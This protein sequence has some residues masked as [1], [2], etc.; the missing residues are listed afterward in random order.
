MPDCRA[1]ELVTPSDTN[2]R[3]P[4]GVGHLGSYFATRE[5]SPAGEAVS[6]MI[7]GGSLGGIEATGSYAGDPYLV[8]RSASG[9]STS[10]AGPSALEAPAISPGSSSPDQGYSFWSTD[11]SEGSAVIEGKQSN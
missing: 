10:Y 3:A 8:T 5:A 11:G 4:Q 1:Y 7:E 9:W 2:A 6:F